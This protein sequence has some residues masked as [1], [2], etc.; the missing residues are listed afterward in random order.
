VVTGGR[1]IRGTYLAENI[2]RG[3]GRLG[4]LRRVVN[5]WLNTAG[6]R[7]NILN[8]LLTDSGSGISAG[9]SEGEVGG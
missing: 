3:G 1:R 5:G 6:Q 7:A 8:G 4:T 2:A 9:T